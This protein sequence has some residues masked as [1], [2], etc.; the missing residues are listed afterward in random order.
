[1][2]ASEISV[3]FFGQF[4][5]L[6]GAERSLLDL[7]DGLPRN[8]RS[9]VIL[10]GTGPLSE[11]LLKRGIRVII[12]PFPGW[13]GRRFMAVRGII[14]RVFGPP[15]AML[16]AYRARAVGVDVV[17]SNSLWSHVGALTARYLKRPHIW[18]IREFVG[19]SHYTRF[20]VG[21]DFA[22]RLLRRSEHF[23]F[24]SNAVREYFVKKFA[25]Q[26]D[27]LIYN[28]ILTDRLKKPLQK[29]HGTPCT[30]II[31]GSINR[32]KNQREAIDAVNILVQRGRDV[33][34]L[35][36][37]DGN[38]QYKQELLC[39][40]KKHCL[41]SHIEFA[42]FVYNVGEMLCRAGTLVLCSE[43]EPF[44]RILVEAASVGCP[45]IATNSGG[46]PEIVAHRKTGLLY[47]P[48]R[49]DQLAAAIEEI[50][51]NTAL[52]RKLRTAAY[53]YVWDA[54]RRNRYAREISEVIEQVVALQKWDR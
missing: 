2:S 38:R 20:A 51:D 7:L 17:Y 8:I 43:A 13:I 9:T 54:F 37:G 35:I 49:P 26:P 1:M 40:V 11:E 31:A 10:P 27:S 36:V 39:L 22:S 16:C 3:L 28:G 24:N 52:R 14:A 47:E 44:G 5:F 15:A 23:I 12:I 50:L 30:V 29:E 46:A 32:H 45:I 48:G 4:P 6:Y 21:E 19:G 18:H 34:L 42:G 33:R 41:E 25:L 53:N